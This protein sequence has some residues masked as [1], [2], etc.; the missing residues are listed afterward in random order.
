MTKTYSYKKDKSIKLTDHF[1]VWEFQSKDGTDTIL[2]NEELPIL[3]ENLYKNLDVKYGIKSI[4]IVSGYRTPTHSVKVGGYATDQHTKGNASDIN[5]TLKDGKLLD[6]KKICLELEDMGHHGGIGYISPTN[7][8]IDVR[9]SKVYFDETNK[10]KTTSSWYSYWNIQKP[11]EL[12]KPIVCQECEE[13]KRKIKELES[14][15]IIKEVIIEKEVIKEVPIE[16]E[17]IKEVDNYKE[18]FK[19]SESKVYK[20]RLN[21]G[22]KLYIK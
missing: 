19:A 6:A 15:P 10:E 14:N 8:H 4:T 11:I 2:I 17:I 7:V 20:I 16:K 9:G 13:Y 21:K 12:P 1:S 22:T 18:V 5:V 3:L